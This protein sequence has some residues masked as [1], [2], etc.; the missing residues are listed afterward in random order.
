MV[1]AR[2]ELMS[3][4]RSTPSARPLREPDL[5]AEIDHENRQQ[6]G[7]TAENGGVDVG[8]RRSERTSRLLGQGE[9]KPDEKADRK[10]AKRQRDGDE[11]ASGDLIA[12]A[13]YRR[14]DK[15]RSVRQQVEK[16]DRAAERIEQRRK[17]QTAAL[18]AMPSVPLLSPG[19]SPP[20]RRSAG[21]R[22]RIAARRPF[23]SERPARLI[24]HRRQRQNT[25]R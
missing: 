12:P 2:K 15:Q 4:P 14:K 3:K 5:Q 16:A 18:P 25:C 13:V 20:F 21:M 22:R 19:P 23:A 9:E 7:Q 17:R 6:F 10:R 11:E 1:P 8:C 24:R